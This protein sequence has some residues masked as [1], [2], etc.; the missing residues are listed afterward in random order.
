MSQ[1]LHEITRS[2]VFDIVRGHLIDTIDELEDVE[3]QPTDSLEDLGASSLDIVEI[4]SCSM[5][6]L[7]VK[8]PRAELGKLENIGQLVD[9]LHRVAIG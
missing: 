2:Q 6:D 1:S 9:L 5:R 7:R 4:V 3:V 8:V